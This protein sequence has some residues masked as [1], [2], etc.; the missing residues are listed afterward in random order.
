MEKLRR[1]YEMK[2]TNNCCIPSLNSTVLTRRH[3]LQGKPRFKEKNAAPERSPSETRL[4]L[5]NPN[6]HLQHTL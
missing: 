2:Q 1:E 3:L 6:Q 4:L 5:G